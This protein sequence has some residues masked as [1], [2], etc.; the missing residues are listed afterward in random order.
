MSPMLALLSFV[1]MIADIG[2]AGWLCSWPL[3]LAHRLALDNDIA[4]VTDFKRERS[5]RLLEVS[6]RFAD[7]KWTVDVCMVCVATVPLDQLLRY[8]LKADASEHKD[9]RPHPLILELVSGG[10]SPVTRTL[11]DIAQLW[12][13]AATYCG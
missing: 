7:R 1:I 2:P 8:L 12:T 6:R 13:R 9:E 5:R 4:D 11:I 10:F 3:E